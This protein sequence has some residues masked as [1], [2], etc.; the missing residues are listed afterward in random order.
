LLKNEV[1]KRNAPASKR[2][3][4]TNDVTYLTNEIIKLIH[5]GTTTTT[6]TTTTTNN[7]SQDISYPQ[8]TKA[9]SFKIL[10]NFLKKV[11]FDQFN[12]PMS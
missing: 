4:T 10:Y 5:K 6:A 11:T 8:T 12:W 2:T 9:V 1:N 7:T 3:L